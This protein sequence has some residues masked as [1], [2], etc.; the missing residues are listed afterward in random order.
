VTSQFDASAEVRGQT[1]LFNKLSGLIRAGELHALLL[2]DL[3]NLNFRQVGHAQVDRLLE[4]S[5]ETLTAVSHDE[6]SVFR[7][8]RDAFAVVLPASTTAEALSVAERICTAVAEIGVPD[9][10]DPH[11]QGP[12]HLVC[13]V[14]LAHHPEDGQTADDL[15]TAALRAMADAKLVGGGGVVMAGP[16]SHDI[17]AR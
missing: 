5:A 11:S 10:I 17:R 14:G 16:A 15:F 12:A 13:S 9:S 2:I 1:A 8:G 4:R 6:D 7:Y 3:D